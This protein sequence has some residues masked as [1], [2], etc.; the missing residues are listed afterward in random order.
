MYEHLLWGHI[1]NKS[2][3]ALLLLLLF[4]G[5]YFIELSSHSFYSVSW[6]FILRNKEILSQAQLII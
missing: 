4:G 6:N 1:G 5:D 3:F 2:S